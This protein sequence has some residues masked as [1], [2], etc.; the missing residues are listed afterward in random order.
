MTTRYWLGLGT[1]VAQKN[2]F[3]IGGTLE[4]GDQLT[5]TMTAE[6]LSTY[7]FTY[8]AASS[9]KAAEAILMA[10]AWNLSTNALC[11]PIT[12]TAVSDTVE[13]LADVAGVPFYAAASTTESGGGAADDQTFEM[14]ATTPNAGPS[15]CNDTDNWSGAAVPVSSD[16]VIFDGR[17]TVSA[18]YGMNQT[19][20]DLAKLHIMPS[21]TG[22]IGSA[23]AP[24]IIECAGNAIIQGQG[25]G[26]YLQ[27]GNDAADADIARLVVNAKKTSIIGL[28]SQKNAGGGNVAI[29]TE[30]IAQSG[31]LKLYGDADKTTTGAQDGT[32][33]G[34]LYAAA[35]T[36][37][38]D[39]AIVIGDQCENFKAAV[40]GT[41]FAVKG[42]IA[43]YS[44]LATLY[45]CGAIV[46]IGGTAYSMDAGDDNIGTLWNLAGT[47]NWHP[48]T[49]VTA[50][51][52]QASVSPAI[53]TLHAVGGVFDAS[54]M[55]N[56]HTTAPTI[57]ALN[58]Y[59][60]SNVSLAN[61]YGNVV[62][63]TWTK[64]GGDMSLS[65][66]QSAAIS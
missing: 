46:A 44:D 39:L 16:I 24:L 38:S 57:T 66:G 4:A 31:Q 58:Q 25:T 20:V 1:A 3:T 33:F 6:N 27:C 35:L 10:A 62:V 29:F 21:Y 41:I 56:T 19:G 2:T 13:L 7:D 43:C 59:A 53:T 61:N 30:I 54:L 32:A 11:T 65:P 49:V 63:T 47:L 8:E 34:T 22:S 9:D 12:A 45:L 60:S 28:S 55:K 37:A 15:D 36:Q 5:I 18:L 26:Y 40:A 64:F 52:T 50:V 48:S 51:E 42:T 17:T 14:A 23:G